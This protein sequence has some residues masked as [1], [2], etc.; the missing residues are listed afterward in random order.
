M[1]G[2]VLRRGRRAY[3]VP[4]PTTRIGAREAFDETVRG[5]SREEAVREASRCLDCDRM[6][7]LCGS[8][9]PSLALVTYPAAPLAADLAVL[10]SSGGRVVAASGATR[11]AIEQGLQVA[12]LADLCNACG[13]C[14][15]ACPT[16]G[17]PYRDKPR[18]F[19]DRADFLAEPDNAYRIV[20][21]ASIEARIGGAT[22]RVDVDGDRVAYW[23]P[24]LAAELDRATLEVLD[25]A[26]TEAPDGTTWPLEPVAAMVALLDGLPRS[27]PFLPVVGR[28]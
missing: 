17:R 25:V 11:V 8:V 6:C 2:L 24:G 16:A 15:T 14:V 23:A 9:C 12:V 1:R 21:P 13:T 18:L 27:L 7:S 22:H 10:V 26:P 19:L 3:R 5:Y 20:A 4:V 28:S